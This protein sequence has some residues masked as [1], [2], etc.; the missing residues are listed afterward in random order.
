M[1]FVGVWRWWSIRWLGNNQAFVPFMASSIVWRKGFKRYSLDNLDSK[2]EGNRSKPVGVTVKKC[3]KAPLIL[4]WLPE[5]IALG[6]KYVFLCCTSSSV[7]RLLLG[8]HVLVEF[9]VEMGFALVRSLNL[10][11]LSSGRCRKMLVK[12]LK[13]THSNCRTW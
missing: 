8:R 6:E 9:L 13:C 5:A 10:V 2:L 1:V 3:K 4:S 11:L 12:G 7:F